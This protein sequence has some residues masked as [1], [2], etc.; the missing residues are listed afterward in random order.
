MAGIVISTT[1]STA[2]APTSSNCFASFSSSMVSTSHD[3]PTTENR[4]RE[5]IEK[6]KKSKKK[7]DKKHKKREMEEKKKA[8]KKHS[9]KSKKKE[10]KYLGEH[11]RLIRDKSDQNDLH[12][13]SRDP[14]MAMSSSSTSSSPSSPSSSSSSSCSSSTSSESSSDSESRHRHKRRRSSSH[15]SSSK[16]NKMNEP[17]L[18]E[19][20][21]RRLAREGGE[22]V[23]AAEAVARHS[24]EDEEAIFLASIATKRFHGQF[25]S[26]KKA[27]PT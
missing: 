1:V 12:I 19:L 14:L 27:G 5:R 18:A 16:D 26:S 25:F 6:S 10:K 3:A 9:K 7:K 15:I 4:R 23:R 20:R 21:A 24:P 2:L 22:R 17:T 13:K 11:N 8:S